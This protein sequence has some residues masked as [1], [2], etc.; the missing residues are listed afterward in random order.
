MSYKLCFVLGCKLVKKILLLMPGSISFDFFEVTYGEAC[1]FGMS[2]KLTIFCLFLE[3]E[4]TVSESK[5]QAGLSH[6]KSL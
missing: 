1:E 5:L 6:T 3:L 2:L 4:N